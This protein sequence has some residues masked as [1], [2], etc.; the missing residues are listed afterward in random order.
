MLGL[1]VCMLSDLAIEPGTW[2]RKESTL[3]TELKPLSLA[4]P[5]R[6]R[7]SS[8]HLR[9]PGTVRVHAG[10]LACSRSRRVSIYSCPG[11]VLISLDCGSHSV[12]PQN[13]LYSESSCPP[14]TFLS[15]TLVFLC[16]YRYARAGMWRL[17]DQLQEELALFLRT[18]FR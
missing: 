5:R 17:E 11:F 16:V 2:C 14:V 9:P 1:Q 4:V 15:F 18:E 12:T 3:P 13:D 10:T 6:N 7:Y 8:Y